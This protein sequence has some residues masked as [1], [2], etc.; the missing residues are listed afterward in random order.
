M[1]YVLNANCSNCFK[2]KSSFVP[3]SVNVSTKCFFPKVDRCKGVSMGDSIRLRR[4]EEVIAGD[5]GMD[6][7]ISALTTYDGCRCCP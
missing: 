3:E 2:P 6:V 1:V 5:W 7:T 4:W